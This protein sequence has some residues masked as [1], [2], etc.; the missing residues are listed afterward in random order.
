M[1]YRVEELAAAA[2]VRVDTVRFYQA[3]GL[4]PPPQRVKREAIY[5]D[6]HLARLKRIRRYQSQGFTLA[7]IK[8]LL[9]SHSRSTGDA[10]LAAVVDQS[11]EGSLTR[12]EVATMSGVPEPL[13]AAIESAG[14]IS[15]A[16]TGAEPRYA[17]A[18]VRLVRA[19]LE[20]VQYG[21]P[22]NELLQ[23][24]IRHAKAV[25]GVA[26][27]AVDLFDR[28]V[29]KAGTPA[30]DPDTVA[31]VFRQLLPV[32]TKM[33]AVHFQRTLLTRALQRLRDQG[34]SEALEAAKTAVESG[35]LEVT[36]R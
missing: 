23:L 14:L 10:L 32:V 21:F 13:L 1:T 8:R 24:A 35:R 33:V 11:G 29:R 26:D 19:G 2:G 28:F 16:T 36:W 17:E 5:S 6:E 25:E 3:K 9:T 12:A 31:E 22:L 7:L 20:I 30:A 4:L 34:Q 18:D 15:P 27:G